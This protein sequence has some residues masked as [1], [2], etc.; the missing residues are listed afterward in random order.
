LNYNQR[1]KKKIPCAVNT[2]TERDFK[3]LRLL[4]NSVKRYCSAYFPQTDFAEI[5]EHF[6]RVYSII[7]QAST[8]A[9]TKKLPNIQKIWHIFRQ[10]DVI[11]AIAYSYAKNG[12]D[13][14]VLRDLVSD[15]EAA[16]LREVQQILNRLRDLSDKEAGET[17]NENVPTG[18][19]LALA[20][21]VKYPDWTDKKIA[22]AIGVSRTTLYD[23]PNFRK[24]KE[25]LKQG[26]NDLPNGSK[27]G[28]TGDMEA[29]DDKN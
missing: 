14:N 2:L 11:F 17:K 21:L 27:D 28:E 9:G 12:L 3:K 10:A 4:T 20:M 18:E 5:Q 15:K 8:P 25:T 13:L 24:A 16:R 23:W 1:L 7:L 29:W 22:K 19:A 26:K 6:D